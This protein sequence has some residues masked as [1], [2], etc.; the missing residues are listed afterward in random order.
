MATIWVVCSLEQ[1]CKGG[2]QLSLGSCSDSPQPDYPAI[3]LG[4]L[5]VFLFPALW[6]HISFASSSGPGTQGIPIQVK[7]VDLFSTLS[8][9]SS[10]PSIRQIGNL[11]RTDFRDGTRHF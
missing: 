1:T 9:P 8:S 7:M 4:C 3:L 2:L 11:L 5:L 10:F 6:Y